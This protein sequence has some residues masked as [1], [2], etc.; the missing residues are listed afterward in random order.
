MVVSCRSS[1]RAVIAAA[2][3]P[4]ASKRWALAPEAE[5]GAA[6]VADGAPDAPEVTDA[7]ADV[8]DAPEA[9]V[10]ASAQLK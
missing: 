5:A 2:L 3:S 1:T 10:F 7:V 4:L 6:G 9:G 8:T